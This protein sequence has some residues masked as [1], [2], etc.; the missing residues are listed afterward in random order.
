MI[1]PNKLKE[2]YSQASLK[3]IF[4]SKI[5]WQ[6]QEAHT[7]F[8]LSMARQCGAPSP[9]AFVVDP[10]Q[11]HQLNEHQPQWSCIMVLINDKLLS[12]LYCHEKPYERSHRCTPTDIPIRV[13]PC[14][15]LGKKANLQWNSYAHVLFLLSMAV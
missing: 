3:I 1:F 2:K 15:L 7:T 4:Q 9:P 8:Y 10:N 11:L 12:Y 5:I 6:R 13:L 14:L